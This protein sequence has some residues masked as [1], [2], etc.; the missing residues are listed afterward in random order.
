MLDV[1]RAFEEANGV[2]IPY[3]ITARR[4]GDVDAVYSD[5]SKAEKELHWKAEKD[6]YDMCRDSWRWQRENPNGYGD[7]ETP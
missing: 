5:P 6:L 1:V 2:K 4:P 3:E 7:E